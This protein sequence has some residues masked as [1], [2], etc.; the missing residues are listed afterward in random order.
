MNQK[1]T[2]SKIKSSSVTGVAVKELKKT[3]PRN[4]TTTPDSKIPSGSI[5]S[6]WTKHK[7]DSAL[8]NPANRRKFT[9]IV[10]GS[11][12]AGGAAAATLSELGYNVK[13]FCCLLY[14]SPSPR[15]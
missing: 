6:K 9:A 4:R 8:I 12:L 14:T 2:Q 10:V 13:C 3:S 1:E 15:D 5:D 7:M 11:G